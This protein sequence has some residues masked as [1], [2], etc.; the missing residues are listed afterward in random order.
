[1][2][3]VKSAHGMTAEDYKVQCGPLSEFSDR[4]HQCTLCGVKIVWHAQNIGQHLNS[5]HKISL[6]EY[7]YTYIKGQPI[8]AKT[9]NAFSIKPQSIHQPSTSKIV[10]P[11]A[12]PTMFSLDPSHWMNRCIFECKICSLRFD[13]RAKLKG[14]VQAL[15]QSNY[16]NYVSDFGDPMLVLNLHCCLMCQESVTCDAEDI[17]EHLNIAHALSL[18]DYH[19]RYIANDRTVST[20]KKQNS[21][22]RNW[23][24]HHDQIH[25]CLICSE[26][27]QFAKDVMESHLKNHGMDLR[28]YEKR[29]R[30][31]LDVIFEAF[32]EIEIENEDADADDDD[33][34]G[35]VFEDEGDEEE[36]LLPPDDEIDPLID[37]SAYSTNNFI[38][39]AEDIDDIDIEENVDYITSDAA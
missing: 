15:H 5:A 38:Q 9:S 24:K 39:T 18:E 7:Y 13:S 17:S 25:T 34:F 35:S 30:Q 27:V 36:L 22:C 14:H 26:Q 31:E 32:N 8:A 37:S 20:A 2:F 3:H 4:K 1:M 11:S 6:K 12:P 33:D 21:L 19:D 28:I 29:F 23:D 10:I 16:D